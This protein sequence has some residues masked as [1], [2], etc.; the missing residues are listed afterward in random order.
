VRFGQVATVAVEA[1]ADECAVSVQTVGY[2]DWLLTYSVLPVGK[3][4]DGKVVW[5]TMVDGKEV[6]VVPSGG[7]RV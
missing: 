2:E 4:V 6:Q 3:F 7:V 5:V 1:I